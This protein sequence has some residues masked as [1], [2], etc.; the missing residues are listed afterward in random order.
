MAG[1]HDAAALRR[2]PFD[3]R[4]PLEG[5]RRHRGTAHAG[6]SR[7]AS[8]RPRAGRR[9]ARCTRD[10]GRRP[11]GVLDQLVPR[12]L[13]GRHDER[14]WVMGERLAIE[15]PDD[16]SEDE[17]N[18]LVDSIRAIDEVDQADNLGPSRSVDLET[19]SVGIQLASQLGG[20]IG[21]V[22]TKIIAVIRGRHIKGVTVSLPDGTT[23]AIDEISSKDLD[24]LLEHEAQGTEG[25]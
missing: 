8:R 20:L 17:Q 21:P 15:L 22:V 10:R 19:I 23:L 11:R 6:A 1:L 25:T 13:P 9:A 18:E 7:G 14:S 3:P 2:R 5:T 12:R 4:Q 16:L 24:R